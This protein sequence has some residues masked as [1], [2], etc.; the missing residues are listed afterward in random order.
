[1]RETNTSENLPVEES[2]P[3]EMN[4][5]HNSSAAMTIEEIPA[6]QPTTSTLDDL[7]SEVQQTAMQHDALEL[8][9]P[10]LLEEI[11]ART[12]GMGSVL[13]SRNLSY[14][15]KRGHVLIY[16]KF[17]KLMGKVMLAMAINHGLIVHGSVVG[18]PTLTTT[19]RQRWFDGFPGLLDRDKLVSNYAIAVLRASQLMAIQQS[20]RRDSRTDREIEA[21]FIAAADRCAHQ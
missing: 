16:S 10:R 19:S 18:S 9:F 2:H 1:M 8:L 11:S 13:S 5:H 15:E 17:L 4:H 14:E 3:S 21:D 6:S 20:D 7:T 12:N